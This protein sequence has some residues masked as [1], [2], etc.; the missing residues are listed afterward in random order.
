MIASLHLYRV[1]ALAPAFKLHR[2]YLLASVD[3]SNPED[4]FEIPYSVRP[5]PRIEITQKR[6][7][8]DMTRVSHDPRVVQPPKTP[9]ANLGYLEGIQIPG[10]D[11]P[12]QVLLR[13][14]K[15]A[16]SIERE[17]S[18][19]NRRNHKKEVPPGLPEPSL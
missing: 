12:D 5:A 15:S 8:P 6:A 17:S 7:V 11:F 1:T 16:A 14:A 19:R 3:V 13:L 4:T 18:R 9:D 10:L 2:L